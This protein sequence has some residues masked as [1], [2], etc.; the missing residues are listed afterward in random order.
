MKIFS[1]YHVLDVINDHPRMWG[2][3]EQDAVGCG[4]QSYGCCM[5]AYVCPCRF[6]KAL[7]PSVTRVSKSRPDSSTNLHEPA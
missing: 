4:M 2:A 1:C 3:K 7:N 6:H 5:A